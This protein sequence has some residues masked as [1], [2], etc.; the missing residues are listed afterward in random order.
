MPILRLGRDYRRAGRLGKQ[1]R[2]V[3]AT[4]FQQVRVASPGLPIVAF[5]NVCFGPMNIAL[6]AAGARLLSSAYCWQHS[7]REKFYRSCDLCVGEAADIDLAQEPIV[8]K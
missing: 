1:Y 8:S 4:S 6:W 3:A 7:C 5:A 2:P